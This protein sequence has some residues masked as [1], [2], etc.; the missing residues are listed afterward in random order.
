[1]NEECYFVIS[2][3]SEESLQLYFNKHIAFQS[4]C[5]YI[6]SFDKNGKLVNSYNKLSTGGY[7]DDF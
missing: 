6:V 7:T 1:M 4:G 3:T 2:N 5:L